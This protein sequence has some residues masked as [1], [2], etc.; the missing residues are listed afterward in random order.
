MMESEDIY[1]ITPSQMNPHCDAYATNEENMLDREGNMVTK[2]GTR[3]T[4]YTCYFP[5]YK[6]MLHWQPLCRFL[7]WKQTQLTMCLK[8]ML[9]ADPESGR[10]GLESLNLS[11]WPNS[12]TLEAWT[13]NRPLHGGYPT[14][15]EN[16]TLSS[17]R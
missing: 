7:V 3:K 13:M 17:P 8:I 4:E 14:R 15:S 5:T 6:K 1:L 12:S 2:K 10:P 9:K 16:M 11:K